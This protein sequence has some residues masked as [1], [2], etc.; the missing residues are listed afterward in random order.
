MRFYKQSITAKKQFIMVPS[1]LFNNE[2]YIGI[3]MTACVVYGKLYGLTKLSNK[4]NWKDEDGAIFCCCTLS[5]MAAFFGFSESTASRALNELVKYGLLERIKNGRGRSDLL[6]LHTTSDSDYENRK[7]FASELE[8]VPE[9]VINFNFALA[10][11]DESQDVSVADVQTENFPASTTE[12]R[13]VSTCVSETNHHHHCHTCKSSLADL[14]AEYKILKN[15]NNISSSNKH[16]IYLYNKNT[17]DSSK[18]QDTERNIFTEDADLI[19]SEDFVAELN[20]IGLSQTAI[21]KLLHSHSVQELR[22]CMSY[23]YTKLADG[24]KIRNPAG[25][26]IY[27][28]RNGTQAS[29]ILTA[30][31]AQEKIQ[32]SLVKQVQK[33]GFSELISN[34]L[35]SIVQRGERFSITEKG[36]CEEIGFQP[37]IIYHAIQANDFSACCICRC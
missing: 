25:L 31:Q 35:I 18:C 29:C 17:I 33:L 20:A 28:V 27:M 1:D 7:I 23:L 32:Q 26:F 14:Q 11:M 19:C 4:N 21:A 36:L 16:D 34:L 2:Q 30:R 24:I 6:Y 12:S 3:S 5:N 8:E 13:E 15:I 10:C 22:T 37:E 9:E